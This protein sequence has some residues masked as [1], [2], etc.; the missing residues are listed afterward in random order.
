MTG[1]DTF[2]KK[3]NPAVLSIERYIILAA[4]LISFIYFGFLREENKWD[5]IVGGTYNYEE[6]DEVKLLNALLH[7]KLKGLKTDDIEKRLKEVR[8]R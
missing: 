4:L 3:P 2:F 7:A 8:G 6:D 1:H 5:E